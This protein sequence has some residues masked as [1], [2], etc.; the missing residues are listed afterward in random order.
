MIEDDQYGPVNGRGR[1]PDIARSCSA[2]CPKRARRE[3]RLGDHRPADQWPGTPNRWDATGP[4][5][6]P[7]GGVSCREEDP[8][9]L[10]KRTIAPMVV[11][12]V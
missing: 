10:S 8:S 5:R 9:G 7:N 1:Q 4:G 11:L 6:L 2:N 3:D 12:P